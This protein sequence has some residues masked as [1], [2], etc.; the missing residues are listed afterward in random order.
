M[1]GRQGTL[2]LSDARKGPC[3]H[4]PTTDKVDMMTDQTWDEYDQTR[5]VC[6]SAS[7]THV[8]LLIFRP[9]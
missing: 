1:Y 6:L 8:R 2:T 5:V 7:G 4:V 3:R 9:A